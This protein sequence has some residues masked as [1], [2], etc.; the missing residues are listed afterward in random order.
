MNKP[1]DSIFRLNTVL[2]REWCVLIRTT[3]VMFVETDKIKTNSRGNLRKTLTAPYIRKADRMSSSR[4][5]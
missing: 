2:E 4:A 5:I 3:S 1:S